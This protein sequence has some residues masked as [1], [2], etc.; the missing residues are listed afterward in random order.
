MQLTKKDF[1]L[2][3]KCKKAFW[4]SKKDSEHYPEDILDDFE[5]KLIDDW[6]EVKDYFQ[7]YF[8]DR[9]NDIIDF[10]KTF[11]TDDGLFA[12]VNGFEINDEGKTCLYEVTSSTKIKQDKKRNHLKEACFQMIVAERSDQ[13]IDHVV[14]F[15]LNSDYARD[16][17]ISPT[18]L[19]KFKD[20]TDEVRA[21]EQEM[22]DE[23]NKALLYLS[24][25][26]IDR[27]GCECIYKSRSHHC[28]AFEY[29]NPTVPNAP[30][31]HELSI[32]HLPRLSDKKRREL[33]ESD[34]IDL[35]DVPAD[36][37]LTTDP[38]SVF[39]KL[40]L[41]ATH[42]RTP[43]VDKTEITRILNNYQ[44]PLYFFDYET[45]P[46]AVPII[47][48]LRP[49]QHLPVQYS[50]HVLQ[51]NGAWT[52]ED[53]LQDTARLPLNLIEKME[54]DFGEIGSVVSWHASFEKKRNEEMAEWFPNKADFLNDINDRMVDLEDIFKKAYVDARFGGSTSI[55][56]VLPV[57]LPNN[58]GYDG[59]AVQSGTDA[60]DAWEKMISAN[61]EEAKKLADNLLA[62]CK[63]DTLSMVDIYNFLKEL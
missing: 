45:Y 1:V 63:Q 51:E 59:L 4:L 28:N 5:K 48:R 13:K 53:F 30:D 11:E 41:W 52:H 8:R 40:V 14:I 33:I 50:L 12:K 16:G 23:I 17:D 26:E 24:K 43:Q 29:F 22:S 62:Y 47:D 34:M 46:S 42:A 38:K 21:I 20:V 15:Y 25:S 60:I 39:S 54:T 37:K 61:P 32:Y 6:Q 2:Y 56:K 10:Q 31:K 27:N 57:I 36:Y 3:L 44:F 55:K 9:G 49:H 7:I 19:F 58:S 18:D 35:H